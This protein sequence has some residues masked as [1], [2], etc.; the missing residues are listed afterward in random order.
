MSRRRE[1]E[2]EARSLIPDTCPAIDAEV[3]VTVSSIESE[4][5][6]LVDVAK[7]QTTALRAALIDAIAAR[8]E[9]E[10][11][12]DDLRHDVANLE[13]EVA[14]LRAMLAEVNA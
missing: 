7:R 2:R 6:A 8:L 5:G 12:R 10:A 13:Q 11:E 3:N 14:N 4:I 1:A 9:V